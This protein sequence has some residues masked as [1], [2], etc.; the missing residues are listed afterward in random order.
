[1]LVKYN[2]LNRLE[3]PKLTLCNPGS[4]FDDGC[5]TKYVGIL[6]DHEAEELCLNFNATSELNFR[7]NRVRRE[8][9]EEN[10]HTYSL[11]KSVQNRRLVF[12]DDIGYFMITNVEDG[13]EDKKHFK[14][15]KAKS[16]DVEIQQKMIPYIADG[17]Y[18]FTSNSSGT[19]KGIIE[20]IVETLPLWT[21]GYIDESVATR[22][23][24]FEDVDTS[25]NCL[26]YSCAGKR[27]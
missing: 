10:S 24:T 17:T 14:D 2:K 25:L 11:Y 6:N 20:T 19:E 12:V 18:K 21:I 7:V 9:S 15:V 3:V 26:G 5:L 1:M 27:S 8:N 4:V 22:W 23:R 13:Y 16:I